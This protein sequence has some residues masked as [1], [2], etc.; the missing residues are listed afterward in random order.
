MKNYI[1]TLKILDDQFKRIDLG[2]PVGWT[3]DNIDLLNMYRCSLL[4]ETHKVRIFNITLQLTN[5]FLVTDNDISI[6]KMPF[7]NI[8]L[9]TKIKINNIEIWGIGVGEYNYN[10]EKI[11]K[12]YK[13]L[14]DK[15]KDCKTDLERMKI[16]WEHVYEA[17][18]NDSTNENYEDKVIVWHAMGLDHNDD[19]IFIINSQIFGDLEVTPIKIYESKT[20]FNTEDI[21]KIKDNISLFVCNFLDFLHDP[22]IELI[23]VERTKEQN[24]KRIKK[25]KD[26]LPTEIFIR[27]DG[28]LKIYLDKL[29]SQLSEEHFNHKFWVRGHWRT[30]RDEKYKKNIGIKIWIRPYIK[31]QGILIQK[32]YILTK[33]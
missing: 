28:T 8:F 17:W 18:K 22:E 6:R 13:E 12:I 20:N 30:L 21:T 23:T 24:D 16:K 31:G 26:I 15:M 33:Q 14:E 3:I 2:L 25:N 29:E 1:E 4:H 5:L 9:D 11:S 27:L 32:E 10:Q 19:T 7:D